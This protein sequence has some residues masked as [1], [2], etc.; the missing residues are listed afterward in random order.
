MNDAVLKK[1][2]IFSDFLTQAE[3]DAVVCR[4]GHDYFKGARFGSF[5]GGMT[6]GLYSWY[7][8]RCLRKD[9]LIAD[10]V[11]GFSSGAL[12]PDF[13]RSVLRRGLRCQ[14]FLTV[15]CLCLELTC[16]FKAVKTVLSHSRC[17]EF[18]L[19]DIGF[20]LLAQMAEEDYG[21]VSKLQAMGKEVAKECDVANVKSV[22]SNRS[23]A[24]GIPDPLNKLKVEPESHSVR[25]TQWTV[26]Q[27]IQKHEH[28]LSSVGQVSEVKRMPTFMDGVAVGLFGSI[29]DCFLPQHS[30]S[31]YFNMCFGYG[32]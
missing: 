3:E 19:D 27:L 14:P 21:V 25:E 32:R 5:V 22:N 7:L 9:Q 11:A 28:L 24:Q 26:K 13:P 12:N 15:S 18:A 1:R 23:R 30:P 10:K 31:A 16:A 29:F 4:F 17:R 20:D 6:A 2:K 8:Y